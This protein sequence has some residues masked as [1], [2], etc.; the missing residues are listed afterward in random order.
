[1]R[2]PLYAILLALS[3]TTL[4]S[5]DLTS[6][7]KP[8]V[9]NGP[10]I[11]GPQEAGPVTPPGVTVSPDFA[12]IDFL[13]RSSTM[14]AKL[15]DNPRQVDPF[16][17]PMDP[18]NAVETPVLADQ[19]DDSDEAQVLNAN[20]LESVLEDLPITGVYPKR[21]MIVVGARSFERGGH[22]GMKLEELTI[23]LRFE[24]IKGNSL[25]FKDLDTQEI[26]S[27]DFNTRPK[28]FEPITSKSKAPRGS[29]IVG[30]DELFIVD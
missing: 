14:L 17:M 27:V 1:M 9:K 30:M 4:S 12:E 24:G 13:V 29:G 19:Y 6:D 23:R 8:M 7:G 28:E 3:C 2:L 5:Q 22:L 10:L 18:T 11:S 21:Q 26:A 25:Y 16:G 20:S 15:E